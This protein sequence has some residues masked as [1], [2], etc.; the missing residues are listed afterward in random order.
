MRPK[1]LKPIV[2]LG[3]T[4]EDLRQ[5]P[6]EVKQNIGHALNEAQH[7]EKPLAAKPLAGFGG[8]SVLEISDDDES[9]TYRA[10]YTVKFVE[11]IFV[12]HC[13]Q[14]KSKKGIKTPRREIDL[15]RQRLNE[16]REVSRHLEEKE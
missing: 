1:S 2:W 12:L 13:F 14:K 10:V 3:S 7:G 9:G 11:R 16:A 8:A 5:M 6:D 15:I 4:L